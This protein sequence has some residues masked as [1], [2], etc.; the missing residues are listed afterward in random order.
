MTRYIVR[1]DPFAG[2][3]SLRSELFNDGALPGTTS[4]TDIY[5][6]EDRELVVEAH[7]PKFDEENITINLAQGA[8]VIRAE[9]HNEDKNKKYLIRESSSSFYR[10]IDLPEQAETEQ[11]D[12]TFEGGVLRVRVPLKRMPAP[13]RIPISNEDAMKNGT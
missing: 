8:L 12:A 9:R 5:T 13:T 7:L 10:S 4:T 3:L 6:N 1:F 2:F 11:I